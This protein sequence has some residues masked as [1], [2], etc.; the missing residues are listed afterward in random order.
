MITEKAKF[1]K[2]HVL[3]CDFL[4]FSAYVESE[5]FEPERCFRI[6]H[7]LDQLLEE[8]N[9]DLDPMAIDSI[10][11]SIP[12]YTVTPEATY[13]SDS[14]VI[15][16]PATNFDAIWLCEAAARIQNGMC[17]HGF[18]VRGS[19]VTGQLY[20]SGNTI[21]GPA[22]TK[23]VTLDQ[24][25]NPPVIVIAN[26]TLNIFRLAT[27]EVDKSIIEIRERQLIANE[28]CAM[29]YVD[30]FWLSKIHISQPT[31]SPGTI[32]NIESWRS[33]IQ[34]GLRDKNPKVVDK[35]TWMAR[36]FNLVLSNKISAVTPIT[37]PAPV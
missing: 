1:E 30:P 22:I 8:A 37:L 31:I 24:H 16:T 2:R 6:F 32:N 4:G 26:E 12:T 36:R 23:A 18:L 21:F 10:S 13:C 7:Q 33:L 11:G 15:S 17:T 34:I 28:N 9:A 19:I 3:Y 27:S 14:I 35:Y 20:H 5:F 29:P 25:G